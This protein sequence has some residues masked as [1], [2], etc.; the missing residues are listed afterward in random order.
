MTGGDLREP[1]GERFELRFKVA[2]DARVD[3]V[4]R[5]N[6][7]VLDDAERDA[8]AGR[9]ELTLRAPDRPGRYRVR[10]TATLANTSDGDHAVLVVPR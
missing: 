8:N 9:G 7:R 4:I 3:A 5:G 6:G 2:R 1:A 10:L